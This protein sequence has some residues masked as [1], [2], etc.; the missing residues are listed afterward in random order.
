MLRI[1]AIFSAALL[2]AVGCSAACAGD[3][4]PRA[5]GGVTV[6]AADPGV[7]SGCPE[8]GSAAMSE[9]DSIATA[10]SSAAAQS[11]STSARR[12]APVGADEVV[13]DSHNATSSSAGDEDKSAGAPAVVP[14]KAKSALRWQSLLPGVMK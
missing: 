1:Q 7:R 3:F 14:H 9:S 6:A 2:F 12:A 11:S 13:A 5:S 4:L 10:H 8:T